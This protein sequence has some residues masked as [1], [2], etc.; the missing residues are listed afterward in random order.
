M[1][2]PITILF[3]A[4]NP[5]TETR[6]ALGREH[7]EVEDR[8]R[9]G[10]HR[11]A[12][13]LQSRWAVRPDDLQEALLAHQPH[14]VHFSGHGSSANEL[15][16][17]D[18]AGHARPV[19][20]PALGELF[21]VLHDNVCLVMLNAC[22]SLPQAQAIAAHIDFVVGMSR[23]I[24]DKAAIAFATAF[25]LGIAYGRSV[26]TAF[27]LGINSLQVHGIPEDQTPRLLVREGA[28]AGAILTASRGHTGL[29]AQ[30]PGDTPATPKGPTGA[31]APAQA[32][33]PGPTVTSA[34]AVAPVAPAISPTTP[35][36][37]A[38]PPRPAPADEGQQ[39]DNKT[40]S[41][42]V[43]AGV[44]VFGCL[45]LAFFVYVFMFA[46]TTLPA[47]KQRMLGVSLAL[48]AGL[49]GWFLAG[50]LLVHFGS[51]TDPA[52]PPARRRMPKV[53]G[54]GGMALVVLVLVWWWSPWS[55]I[56]VEPSPG[57]EVHTPVTLDAR[58]ADLP[59][60]LH[61]K[62]ATTDAAPRQLFAGP[63]R[64]F[65]AP[66]E[67]RQPAPRSLDQARQ[68]LI[69]SKPVGDTR[70]FEISDVVIVARRKHYRV[71]VKASGLSAPPAKLRSITLSWI[72]GIDASCAH[73]N[74]PRAATT[75][76][77]MAD[78]HRYVISNTYYLFNDGSQTWV[79]SQVGL[80]A[81]HRHAAVFQIL[82]PCGG[83]GFSF[84]FDITGKIN[85]HRDT[86]II[87]DIPMQIRSASGAT[88][89]QIPGCRTIT[90]RISAGQARQQSPTAKS[91]AD[92]ET[93]VLSEAREHAARLAR[94]TRPMKF[95]A[96][97]RV[98]VELT[99]DA[100]RQYLVKDALPVAQLSCQERRKR[101]SRP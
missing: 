65:G 87:V 74:A 52:S 11:N 30:P 26:R 66:S 73:S 44:W 72:N 10:L 79:D 42:Q 93:Q 36:P 90:P 45:L 70:A 91:V 6:L 60:E 57:S 38:A 68:E 92:I 59:D 96:W 54:M 27:D 53:Q 28:D 94:P 62:P 1:S 97:S 101:A 25:Y 22:F 64:S 20:G 75:L 37:G 19:S 3:L 5:S 41:R 50:S 69:A 23:A 13:R 78:L 58:V 31:T 63:S 39:P 56:H 4:A 61:A 80:T 99:T 32:A 15:I 17:E 14:I 7:R 55:P 81:G 82:S 47:Y 34:P 18:D 88:S 40:S 46:P 48:L 21:R 77:E 24:S 9:S 49:M 16:L 86:T 33:P 98:T 100:G 89:M 43:M 83:D 2:K 85:R 67:D 51:D 12:L 8:I 35:E 95:D 84:S 76:V 29:P 71:I